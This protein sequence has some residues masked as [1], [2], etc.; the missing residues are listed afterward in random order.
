[1][2]GRLKMEWQMR[3]KRVTTVTKANRPQPLTPA[4]IEKITPSRIASGTAAA[5][6][7]GC[8]R[9]N[10]DCVL[11][12]RDPTIGSTIESMIRPR[13]TDS[14]ASEFGSPQTTVT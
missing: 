2:Y 4:G 3:S 11:S 14:P 8:R 1:M 9:P 12:E 7:K 5:N 10:L 13:K 6:M